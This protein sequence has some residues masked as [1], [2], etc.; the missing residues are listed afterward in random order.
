M[1]IGQ[2]FQET[3]ILEQELRSAMIVLK[4]MHVKLNIADEFCICTDRAAAKC[5]DTNLSISDNAK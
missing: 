3:S 5:K 1:N 4:T 2:T